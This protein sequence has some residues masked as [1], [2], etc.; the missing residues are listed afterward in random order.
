[1]PGW[2][3]VEDTVQE[4]GT[5][6]DI[7]RRESLRKLSEY[8]S[9]NVIIYYSGWLQ[10]LGV[11]LS[12]EAFSIGD[13]DKS[14]FMATIHKMDTAKGLD[15]ILH[16]PGGD[17]AAT[18]SLGD[19]LRTKFGDD[20][21]VIVPQ[22]ALSAGTMLA[23]VAR[24]IIMGKHSSLGPIDPQFGGL[25]A[26]GVIEEFRQAFEGVK[27]DPATAPIWSVVIGKYPPAFVGMCQQAVQ[28][29]EN[30]VRDWLKGGGMFRGDAD[31]D[32]KAD[33]IAKG[34]GDRDD[35]K[36]HNRHVSADKAK[37]LGLVVTML[38]DDKELQEFVLTVHHCCLQTLGAT[39]AYKLIE[40]QEGMAVISY[41]APIAQ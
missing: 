31:A 2:K 15:L 25:P 21:R 16:T 35:M 29:S 36:T 13:A 24:E 11:G 30:M 18:E 19:Y 40:N 26:Q 34:L 12:A 28:W 3:D 6:Y 7:V 37:S 10:K 39:T 32:L 41:W 14:G 17:T 1:M 22:L 20:I 23:C 33:K 9:R 4:R 27:A 5:V 38:E 8:T